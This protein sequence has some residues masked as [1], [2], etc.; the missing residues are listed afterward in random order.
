MGLPTGYG[1]LLEVV[2]QASVVSV[3]HPGCRWRVDRRAGEGWVVSCWLGSC[4]LNAV[5]M[6]QR[7][8]KQNIKNLGGTRCNCMKI[9]GFLWMIWTH[10]CLD[11]CP[12]PRW[13]IWGWAKWDDQETADLRWFRC[14]FI[15]SPNLVVPRYHRI[16]DMF[17]SLF[18]L[19]CLQPDGKNPVKNLGQYY[20]GCWIM[21]DP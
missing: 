7:C 5:W 3:T 8:G 11:G 4:F 18:L 12:I 10:V 21:L 14:V 17:L 9:L 15:W 13:Y 6:Q 19:L 2:R 20:L 16:I 1:L